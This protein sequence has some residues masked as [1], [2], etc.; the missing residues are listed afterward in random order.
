MNLSK[1]S[2]ELLKRP[3]IMALLQKMAGEKVNDADG[4]VHPFY[5]WKP[6]PRLE[7]QHHVMQCDARTIALTLPNQAGKTMSGSRFVSAR[8]QG[9]EP[10]YPG[11]TY[12]TPIKVWA[13]TKGSLMEG[14]LDEVLTMVPPNEIAKNS[15][16]RSVGRCG[17]KL[18]NGSIFEMRSFDQT[19]DA[20]KQAKVDIVWIDELPS[21]GEKLWVEIHVRLLRT[22][23]ILLLTGTPDKFGHAWLK[24]KLVKMGWGQQKF[25]NAHG[26]EFAWFKA[27]SRDNDMLKPD[28]LEKLIQEIGNDEELFR[29][30][31]LGEWP[32]TEGSNIFPVHAVNAQRQ[33]VRMPS[34]VISFNDLGEV[35]DRVDGWNIY[36]M[37]IP[38]YGYSL[39]VDLSEGGEK[40]DF[41]SAHVIKCMTNEI[42]ATWHGRINPDSFARQCVYA[43][44]W[45]NT[46]IMCPESK[47]RSGGAFI[48][49]IRAANYPNVYQRRATG[50][51]RNIMLKTFGFETDAFNKPRI[52]FEMRK[53][54]VD[55]KI[56]IPCGKT[57]DEMNEFQEVRDVDNEN[58]GFGAIEGNDD[59]V[60][61]L[62]LA[63]EGSKQG[64]V[65]TGSPVDLAMIHRDPSQ[66][67]ATMLAKAAIKQ[68]N[69]KFSDDENEFLT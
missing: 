56:V 66:G 28:A 42:V 13:I 53:L 63:M 25:L 23:G 60:M 31:I 49:I 43:G 10:L 12:E 51:N 30:K 6:R 24:R 14:L 55:H 57:L 11:R 5:G 32:D 52:V 26:G 64:I 2:I 65:F 35:I 27:D 62:M 46:A 69:S 16:R 61:S 44:Y 34:R 3:D 68:A 39:G 22:G 67:Y 18:K 15:I 19:V 8:M 38:G 45:Y 20:F 54:L 17:F 47:T 58:H 21:T 41:T 40:S 48:A 7:Y 29:I 36:E 9:I 4:D 1:D 37:P 33:Y 50:W 59:R